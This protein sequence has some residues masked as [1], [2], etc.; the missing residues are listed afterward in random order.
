LCPWGDQATG[1]PRTGRIF[2]A[3]VTLVRGRELAREFF[4]AEVRPLLEGQ[5]PRVRYAASLIGMLTYPE[6]FDRI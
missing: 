6:P 4:A 1:A 2:S 3:A 5:F